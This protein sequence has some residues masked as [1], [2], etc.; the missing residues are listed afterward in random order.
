MVQKF[1]KK[2]VVVVAEQFLP[3]NLIPYPVEHVRQE[4]GIYIGEMSRPDGIMYATERDWIITAVNGGHHACKPDIM[5]MTYEYV[6]ESASG[7]MVFRKIPNVIEATPFDPPHT[8]PAAVI[9]VKKGK[10]GYVGEIH[11]L[12][13]K[14][15]VTGGSYVVKGAAGEHYAI[16]PEVFW[17]LYEAI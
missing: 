3:P 7:K 9:N 5:E 14:L 17:G 6:G 1:R 4:N 8:I 13:G 15:K 2:P 11:T 16:K 10:N 12:E